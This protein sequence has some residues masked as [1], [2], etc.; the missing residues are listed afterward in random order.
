MTMG[1]WSVVRAELDAL[2]DFIVSGKE[3]KFRKEFRTLTS[4]ESFCEVPLEV[5]ERAQ[6]LLAVELVDSVATPVHDTLVFQLGRNRVPLFSLE[7]GGRDRRLFK[8]CCVYPRCSADLEA[9]FSL[10]SSW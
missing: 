2:P 7:T 10:A 6:S 9:R 8:F 1:E 5:I 3:I 4:H